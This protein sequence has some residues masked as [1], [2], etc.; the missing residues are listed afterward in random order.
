MSDFQKFKKERLEDP[1]VW[2]EY[3]ALRPAMEVIRARIGARIEQHQ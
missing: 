3:E 2:A 1:E